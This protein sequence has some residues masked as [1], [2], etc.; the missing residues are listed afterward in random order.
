MIKRLEIKNLRG[1]RYLNLDI[2]KKPVLIYGENGKG[3]SSIIEAIEWTLTGRISHL[4]ESG[5]NVSF[6][7]HAHHIAVTANQKE[8]LIEFDD[9]SIL[10]TSSAPQSG[11]KAEMFRSLS[12]QGL[13][14]LR[15]SQLLQAICAKPKDR[16]EL[17]RPFLPLNRISEIEDTAQKVLEKIESEKKVCSDKIR[18]MTN[19]I[20]IRLDMDTRS[21]IKGKHILEAIQAI[22]K[23]LA[24]NPP[25]TLENMQELKEIV[26]KETNAV[27][28]KASLLKNQSILSTL[29]QIKDIP[30]IDDQYAQLQGS[31]DEF[32]KVSA[33]KDKLFNETVLRLG[34]QWIQEGHLQQCPLCMNPID[35]QTVC[36]EIM[37][38]VENE[39]AYTECRK[40]YV[41]SADNLKN[42]L[43]K[44]VTGALQLDELIKDLTDVDIEKFIEHIKAISSKMTDAVVLKA[45]ESATNFDVIKWDHAIDDSIHVL[46][47]KYEDII[48]GQGDTDRLIQMSKLLEAIKC[49]D[50]LMPQIS[51]H[52]HKFIELKKAGELAI[53][54]KEMLERQRKQEVQN[55]YNSIKGLINEYYNRIH[56]R[57]PR[58]EL[59]GDINLAIRE[60]GGGSAL[61]Q[62]AF[63]NRRNEDPRS[64][65]SESHLDTLGLCIFLSL[66]KR[67]LRVTNI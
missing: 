7:K 63:Y 2:D 40:Q 37:R 26:E 38:R 49:I 42:L 62:A 15:R 41:D 24:I 39:A 29:K 57:D 66:Y 18:E 53:Q 36:A 20:G 12:G 64:Y 23:S 3:K 44:Y 52:K 46:I 33:N 50:S 65:Y 56:P 14:I 35:A 54:W 32:I 28:D 5:Q 13:N 59:V 17:L 9:S 10:S 6:E 11:T 61:L 16:Y 51:I 30:S 55:I 43:Q 48:Q 34:Y 47:K 27:T 8:A 22:C 21:D 31:F 45:P 60:A 19:Q 1:V 58:T 67:N 25:E 4:N